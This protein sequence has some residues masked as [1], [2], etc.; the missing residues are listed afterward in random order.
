MKFIKYC[1][2]LAVLLSLVACAPKTNTQITS[3]DSS[4]TKNS[5]KEYL[6]TNKSTHD[7]WL[8]YNQAT[9]TLHNRLA[10]TRKILA[11]YSE[12]IVSKHYDGKLLPTSHK[13]ADIKVTKNG[14]DTLYQVKARTLNALVSTKLSSIRSWEFDFLVVVLFDTD[15]KLL[16]VLEVPVATAKNYAKKNNYVNAQAIVTTKDFLNDSNSTDITEQIQKKIKHF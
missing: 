8:D 13:S 4:D 16:K 15:G 3:L 2:A 1:S 6:A 14:A 10:R 7:L 12:F 11:E 5:K 9:N